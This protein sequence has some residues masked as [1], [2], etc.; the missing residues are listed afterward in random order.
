[1]IMSTTNAIEGITIIK[2]LGHIEAKPSEFCWDIRESARM[3][4]EKKAEELGAN[5]IINYRARDPYRVGIGDFA[6]GDAVIVEKR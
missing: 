5:A 6:S 1:M 2:H 3:N 4:L